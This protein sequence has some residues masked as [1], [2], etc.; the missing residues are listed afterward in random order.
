M[1]SDDLVHKPILETGIRIQE[2]VPFQKVV[3]PGIFELGACDVDAL[4]LVHEQ[5]Q[6]QLLIMELI[7]LTAEPA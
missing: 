2:E 5:V 7:V 1:N 6:V 4:D 3:Q